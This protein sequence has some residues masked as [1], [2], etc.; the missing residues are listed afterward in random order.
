MK[1]IVASTN[2]VKI[3][4]V[5]NIS[6][7]FPAL[8]VSHV[9]GIACNTSVPDQ[10]RSFSETLQGA[11]ERAYHSFQTGCLSV[12]IEAGLMEAPETCSG[13]LQF[14]AC[15]IYDGEQFACGTSSGFEVPPTIHAYVEAGHTLSDASYLSGVSARRSI[16]KEEGLISLLSDRILTRTMLTEQAL[17]TAFVPFL[18]KEYYRED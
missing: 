10:P 14:T 16:G 17:L 3:T 1:C 2:P 12:G 9:E 5:K 8:G 4:A 11:K 6:A 15:A 7:R 18:K 13:W